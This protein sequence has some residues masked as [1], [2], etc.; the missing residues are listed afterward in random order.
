MKKI[1]SLIVTFCLLAG[2]LPQCVASAY[3][4]PSDWAADEIYNAQNAGIITNAVAGD[5]QDDITREEFCELIVKLYEK[6]ANQSAPQGEDI[7]IDTSNPEVLKAYNLGIVK[8]VSDNEFAPDSNITRQEICVM[9]V[10]CIAAA[11]KDADISNFNRNDFADSDK[12]ADWAADYVNYAYDSGIIKGMGNN[13]IDPLG[14]TTCEQVVL[15]AYRVYCNAEGISGTTIVYKIN[16]SKT[17]S[18]NLTE[19]ILRLRLNNMGYTEA[20]VNIK[21]SDKIEVILPRQDDIYAFA[22]VLINE[23]CLKFT[24]CNNNILLTENDIQDTY[25]ELNE[26]DNF[27]YVALIFTPEGGAKFREATSNVFKMPYP[28]NYINIMIDNSIIASPRVAQEIDSDSCMISG[29]FSYG[30]AQSLADEIQFAM[31]KY[32][33]EILE[34]R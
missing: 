32:S 24:D 27:Y 1:F 15:L 20:E 13:C 9:L 18:L 29:G 11:V 2:S 8:G 28:N 17:D 10:K 34:T 26:Y 22:K 31:N 30:E 5:Y 4:E 21:D 3:G 19:K 6:I 12:I 7:F 14:N 23:Y 25:T 16:S 33:I